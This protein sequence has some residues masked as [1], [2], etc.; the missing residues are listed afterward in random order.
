MKFYAFVVLLVIAYLAIFTHPITVHASDTL[1]ILTF[2][3]YGAPDSDWEIRE[4]LILEELAILQP[5][6]IGLQ[7]IVQNPAAVVGPDNRAKVLADSLYYRT[8][9]RYDF[10]Y[11][12]TH[13]SWGQFD[14]GI[15]ILSRH[16]ILDSDSLDLPPGNFA[17]KVLWNRILSPAGIINFFDTHLSYGDQEPVRIQQV[18]AIKPYIEQIN[19]DS[20]AVSNILC[21]DFNAIPGS[22]PILLLT[23]PDT[24]GIVYLDSWNEANPGSPGYTVP[25]N[26]PASIIYF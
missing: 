13:F 11:A 12:Y 19:S 21:G 20:I 15:A 14:E 16:I 1:K 7:E 17:R 8:G 2:N 10:R 23:L 6:F 24:N 26:N 3:I 25:S 4:R 5:D 9:I 22:P 18:Q